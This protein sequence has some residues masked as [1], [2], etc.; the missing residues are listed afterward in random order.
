MKPVDL[1]AYLITNNTKGEDIILDTFGGSGSTL[2]AAQ[3]TGRVCYTLEIDPKYVDV[4]IKRWED[5]SGGK[6]EKINE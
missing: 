1:M 6:A 5:Y 3:K 2:I 4:I